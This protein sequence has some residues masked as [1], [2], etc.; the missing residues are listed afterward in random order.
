MKQ[1][2]SVLVVV[3]GLL[4]I[5]AVIGVT[6]LTLSSLER[7]TATS[8]AL[9]TQMMIAADGALDYGVHQMVID[10]W[11][12]R[13][14]PV[15]NT[16]GKFEFT[17]N[18][19][20][21]R[22]AGATD[23]LNPTWIYGACETYDYPSPADDPWLST[24]IVSN[25]TPTWISFGQMGGATANRFGIKFGTLVTGPDNLGFPDAAE[26][27]GIWIPDLVAPCDQ[28]LVRASVT[29][30]DHNALVNLNAHGNKN[31]AEWEYGDCIGKGYFVS[32][33]LPG[34]DLNTLLTG[35]GSVP[36]CWG[37]DAKPGNPKAGAV[38]IE[39]PSDP[40]TGATDIPYTLDEEFELRNLWGTYFQSRLE[41]FWPA[42]L[43][44]PAN[45]SV[46]GYTRRLKTTTVSWTAEVRGDL[47]D[48]A[49]SHAIMKDAAGADQ[50]WSAA[51]VDLNTASADDIYKALLDGRAMDDG[52]E[53]KQFAANIVTLRRKDPSWDYR[54][55]VP[56]SVGGTNY[57]GAVRQPVLSEATC[58]PPVLDETDPLDIKRTYT[59]KVEA[60][61]PWPGSYNGDP[62]GKLRT[63]VTVAFDVNA[64][65]TV[66]PT[67]FQSL[68]LYTLG[69]ACCTPIVERQIVCHNNAT[70]K[71]ALKSIRLHW[72]NPTWSGKI[73]DLDLITGDG[74][75]TNVATLET[76]GRIYRKVD[77]VDEYRGTKNNSPIRVFYVSD[78]NSGGGANLGTPTRDTSLRNS[79]IPIRF[80]NC[81][82]L[83]ATSLPVRAGGAAD[84][85]AFARVGDLNQ[86]LRFLPGPDP[87]G[88]N[89]WWREPWICTVSKKSRI[90]ENDVK[91]DWTKDINNVAAGTGTAAA[92]AANVLS[93]GGPWNDGLD[94]DG[95][96]QI[97]FADKGTGTGQPGG[98]EF[99][100]AGKI[101]L[102]TAIT[103]TLTALGLANLPAKPIKSP[104]QILTGAA[105]TNA[106]LEARDELFSRISNIATV[107]SD[108]FSI[109]G[110]VQ[111]VDPS[112]AQKAANTTIDMPEDIIRTRQFWALVDR[113]PSLAYPPTDSAN[114]IRPRI[115]NFQWLD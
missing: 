82:S 39:N 89:T 61:N 40:L 69:D 10:V 111:I 32:D 12:W 2:A 85:K 29:I 44:D 57:L 50:G 23:P 52:G 55:I 35:T 15:V 46:S 16:P 112:R 98:P 76:T 66:L 7:A 72:G 9:Q 101:N 107:R 53:L 36:G 63:D 73:L 95:D 88:R 68:S 71:N 43:S 11:E 42:L 27:N 70:L 48:L 104:A 110:T 90:Q 94:N 38:L 59:I 91:F 45:A 19:L 77:F 79:A 114:F 20:T 67:S 18:L 97:D 24:P 17:G 108:T 37:A 41:Q 47:A 100:V 6:F 8:F 34:A 49:A 81:V 31:T 87:A 99:R 28:Y 21:G 26:A 51:K 103:E 83:S 80:L 86:V 105:M 65:H 4:A 56:V 13:I 113:S 3:L 109:Y 106:G 25:A 5:L 102:N 14:K 22:V 115:L 78:W 75:N 74:D 60:Y 33:V 1:Q 84:F 64:G 30:L 92:Y 58:S 96:T 93:V 54:N 62:L